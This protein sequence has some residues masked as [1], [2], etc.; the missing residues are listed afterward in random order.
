MFH[1]MFSIVLN[2]PVN[3]GDDKD[4]HD[5]NDVDDGHP[6]DDDQHDDDD[7]DEGSPYSFIQTMKMMTTMITKKMIKIMKMIKMKDHHIH[8]SRHPS[9]CTQRGETPFLCHLHLLLTS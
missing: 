1:K 9:L 5:D 8:A 2:H 7:Q 3:D 4:Y 6:D